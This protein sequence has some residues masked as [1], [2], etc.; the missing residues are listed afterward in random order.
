MKISNPNKME[1]PQERQ[2]KLEKG[3][4]QTKITS[5]AVYNTKMFDTETRFFNRR[6]HIF[7][8]N[9]ISLRLFKINVPKFF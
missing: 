8:K 1:T 4:I 7:R 2:R 6:T 5:T 3:I 9:F